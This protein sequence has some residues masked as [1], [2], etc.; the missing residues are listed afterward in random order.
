M[1][2]AN[3]KISAYVPQDLYDRF[4][5]FKEQRGLSSA[6]QAA[7]VILTEFFGCD[8]PSRLPS[9]SPS[10][11]LEAFQALAQRVDHLSELVNSLT[12]SDAQE[13]ESESPIEQ[14]PLLTQDL[15]PVASPEQGG[16]P[17]GLEGESDLGSAV[18]PVPSALSQGLSAR[19]LGARIGFHYSTIGRKREESGFSA[20][21][22]D[23]DP[24]HIS[25]IYD[26]RVG[27]FFPVS[28]PQ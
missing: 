17:S 22:K 12:V 19:A 2:T 25:W 1:P 4:I 27:K 23:N 21:S 3:P 7:I 8:T 13:H 11:S 18:S 10:V 20:W 5:D 9:S 28:E 26:E 6:S 24:D 15:D 14:L 16:S